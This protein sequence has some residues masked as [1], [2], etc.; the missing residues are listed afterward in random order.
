MR[1]S[2]FINR[3][4]SIERVIP[5]SS[6]WEN[7]TGYLGH[8]VHKDLGLNNGDVGK[9]VDQ[10]GRRIIIIGTYFGN[11]LVFQRH[12]YP[13]DNDL[14]ENMV[15]VLNGPVK[16]KQ[17]EMLWG[18]A[19]SDDVFIRICGNEYGAKN[20]GQALDVLKEMF[21]TEILAFE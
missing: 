14:P 4:N 7:G 20:V 11:V 3:F 21:A 13:E 15:V 2:T 12:S 17:A 16:L 1:K 6:E 5:Y 19:L 9:S 8:A 18:T 10:S